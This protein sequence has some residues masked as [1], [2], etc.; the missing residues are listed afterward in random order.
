MIIIVGAGIFGSM[1]AALARKAGYQVTVIDSGDELAASKCSSGL[2]KHSWLESVPPA[3]VNAGYGVL[4][5]L[6]GITELT[7]DNI[8]GKRFESFQW[9]DPSAVLRPPDMRVKVTQVSPGEVRLING[10][11]LRAS[12]ILVAAGIH[13]P[14]LVHMPQVSALVGSVLRVPGQIA[15]QM[16]VYAP[17]RQA[18][19]FNITKKEVWVGDGTAILAKNWRDERVTTLR[20]R[21]RDFFAIRSKGE[22]RTGARPYVE[23]FKGY[24]ACV[25]PGVW[26]STGGAKNGTL[27]AAAQAREF[28]ESL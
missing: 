14:E 12:A 15:P 28:V 24:F 27:L 9:V 4:R 2:V 23:G 20:A 17:Y 19:A 22:V 11:L 10:K 8:T 3:K 26:V 25:A 21:A 16:Y 13:S 7:F 1:A 18:I 6:Y 5:E